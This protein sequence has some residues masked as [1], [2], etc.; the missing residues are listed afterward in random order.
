[1]PERSYMLIDPRR[2]HFFR[3][4]DP[5]QSKAAGAPDVCTGCHTDKTADW[6]AESIAQWFPQ[7]DQSWQ[8][9]SALIAF[10]AGDRQEKT[11][12]RSHRLRPRPREASHRPG[13][14]AARGCGRKPP[15]PKPMRRNC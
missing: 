11:L 13:H 5:L 4:P 2:D 7:R 1:M 3:R 6:A 14:G 8:D 9:R 15:S 12:G 10:N